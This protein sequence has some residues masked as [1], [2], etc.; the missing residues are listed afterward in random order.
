MRKK[1]KRREIVFFPYIWLDRRVRRKKI[2][3]KLFFL[4]WLSEKMRRKKS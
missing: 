2:G 3:E 1:E 4:V